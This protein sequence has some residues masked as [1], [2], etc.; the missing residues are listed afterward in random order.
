MDI[1]IT[2]EGLVAKSLFKT[3]E[4]PFSDIASIVKQDAHTNFITHGGKSYHYCG[5]IEFV[6]GNLD[7]NL[8][9]IMDRIEEL[10]ISYSEQNLLETDYVDHFPAKEAHELAQSTAEQ[11]KNMSDDIL[12]DRLGS[13]YEVRI[14]LSEKKTG[15]SRIYLSLYR[16]G[17]PVE[18]PEKAR[19]QQDPEYPD[20]FDLIDM[21]YGPLAYDPEKHSWEYAVTV[22]CIAEDARK[23][24]VT[25][26]INDLAD[27]IGE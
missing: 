17:F 21:Y 26:M 7:E 4:I 15:Y 6:T 23:N 8:L 9:F 14:T 2:E 12:R 16:G 19:F 24:T 20:A 3:E 10:G 13:D 22:E 18:L 1:K 25:D 27:I 5:E 11:V